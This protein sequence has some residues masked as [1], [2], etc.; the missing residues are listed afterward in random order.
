MAIFQGN[1]F[2]QAIQR[3]TMFQV[4]LPNDLPPIM[5]KLNPHY[6]RRMKTLYLLHGFSG[7]CLDWLTGSCVNDLAGAYNL[8]VVMAGGDNSFYLNSKGTG[9]AYETFV[10]KEIVEYTRGTFGLSDKKE[11]TFI[12]GLSMGGFGAI[13]TGLCYPQ[14]FGKMFGLSSALIIHDIEGMKPGESNGVADYDYYERIFGDLDHLDE[15]MNNPEAVIRKRL[16]A[17]EKI[18]PI[19]MAC[20]AEDFLIEHNRS[21]RDFLKKQSVE[22][23]YRES[24]GTHEWKFWNEYLEPAI[25][26]LLNE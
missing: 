12:G 22:V 8:A 3:Q 14:T 6:K 9:N 16:K 5:T 24:P 15:S 26:W 18:Q 25:Q 21:F 23:T 17:G 4:A 2:S 11:D 20:G 7:N 10:G 19:F 1:F 13:H